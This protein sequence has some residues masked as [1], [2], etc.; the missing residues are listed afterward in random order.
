MKKTLLLIVLALGIWSINGS[1]QPKKPVRKTTTQNLNKL[2]KDSREYQVGNDGFEWYKV[3]KNGK[4]GA[5]DR[6][7]NMLVPCEFSKIYY[8]PYDKITELI[9]GC[10]FIA[11]K[12]EYCS[13][14]SRDGKCIIPYTRHYRSAYK[15]AYSNHPEIG[16]IYTCTIDNG[17]AFCNAE[18]KEV[19]MFN[20]NS[21]SP[22]PCYEKNKFYYLVVKD[23][24]YGITD[25]LG[26]LIIKA[27]YKYISTNSKGDFTAF[28]D[29]KEQILGNIES[30][31]TTLNP[32]NGNRYDNPASSSNSSSNTSSSSNP[33]PTSSSSSNNSGNGTTQTVVVEHHRDPIPVQEW[34]A[35]FGCG[36]MGTMG[37][38]HCGG[39][40]T[41]YTGDRLHR[42]YRCNGRGIIPCNICYGNKGQY[43]TV[44]R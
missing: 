28:V 25:G 14:Y 42:C 12:E 22:F 3:C 39:S 24:K 41:K 36:G 44:Y 31:S 37:C 4:L 27:D 29:G 34:Q 19:C 6:S 26:K 13:Y 1:A 2:Q 30:I 32:F 11:V 8:Q 20:D 43:I 15:H 40:G 38:D 23:G 10:G 21:Y 9:T 18:G 7:G 35:C 5:E 33:S 17:T 16:T